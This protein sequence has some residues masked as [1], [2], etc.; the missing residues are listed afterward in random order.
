MESSLPYILFIRDFSENILLSLNM[1]YNKYI[2]FNNKDS[3]LKK[4]LDYHD[5]DRTISHIAYNL[6][7]EGKQKVYLYNS[8]NKI[9][10]SL[11]Y[12]E[13]EIIGT[14]KL[15]F[16]KNIMSCFKRKRLL[17]KL[18]KMNYLSNDNYMDSNYPR[19]SIFITELI[20][21]KSTK[22]TK[23]YVSVNMDSRECTDQY[24][25]F[26]EIRK[27]KHQ[28][29]LVDYIINELNK[30]F[31]RFLGI[32]S[33]DKLEF[34]SQSMEE[35]ELIEKEL[36]ENSKT[37]DEILKILYPNRTKKTNNKNKSS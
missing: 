25:L 24:I 14:F 34:V 31:H 5:I 1:D 8:N 19:D 35:L 16:P 27:R 6:L 18:K 11:D 30:N 22:L 3:I 20:K 21:Q 7:I 12:C 10:I 4:N 15:K 2:R 13:E 36:L 32:N 9:I 17:Y 26:R 29:I 28:K 23:K 37:I 33:N